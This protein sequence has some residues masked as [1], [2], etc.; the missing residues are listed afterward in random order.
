[1][2]MEK[3]VKK[4]RKKKRRKR[5]CKY[6]FINYSYIVFSADQISSGDYRVHIF[7]EKA[8]CLNIPVSKRPEILVSVSITKLFDIKTRYTEVKKITKD[9][10]VV[11]WNEHIFVQTGEQR[12]RDLQDSRIEIRIQEKAQDRSTLIGIYEFSLE[13]TH[14]KPQNGLF[15]QWV[16]TIDNSTTSE[17]LSAI[18]GYMKLS[19]QV[20]GELDTPIEISE[21][22]EM[23]DD[24]E[25]TPVLIPIQVTPNYL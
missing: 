5:Q 14:Q 25:E 16:A 17:D 1:M 8:K 4:E 2:V 11:S 3:M 22:S 10:E 7:I 24:G 12:Q 20:T 6:Y 19:I 18:T 9:H 13:N 21:D 23:H 15:H